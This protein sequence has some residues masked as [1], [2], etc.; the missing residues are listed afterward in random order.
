MVLRRILDIMDRNF[1]KVNRL[2]EVKEVK[3]IFYEK[4][5]ECSA[6][7]NNEQLVGV[8]TLRDLAIANQIA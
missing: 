8:L 3:N 7:Y 5:I 2:K 4:N 6:V 1:Y